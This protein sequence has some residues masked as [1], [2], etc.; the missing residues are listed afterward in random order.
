MFSYIFESGVIRL[1]Q[2]ALICPE[3]LLK[4][5]LDP[6]K[7]IFRTQKNPGSLKVSRFYETKARVTKS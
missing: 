1:Y 6:W 3:C 5:A 7:L 2:V 4:G